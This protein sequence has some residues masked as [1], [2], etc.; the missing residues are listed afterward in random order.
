M[1]KKYT[2]SDFIYFLKTKNIE[3]IKITRKMV[4]V[5]EVGGLG[6]WWPENVVPVPINM[7]EET[8]MITREGGVKISLKQAI[9]RDYK[10]QAIKIV[11]FLTGMGLKESKDFVEV[12]FFGDPHR[13]RN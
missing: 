7:D 8:T 10:I 6:Y 5:D 12:N 13:V 2:H 9:Q 4:H 11:R 1:I 3:V